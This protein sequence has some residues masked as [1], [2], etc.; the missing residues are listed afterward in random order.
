M[1]DTLGTGTTEDGTLENAVRG[2]F[3]FRPGAIIRDLDLLRPVYRQTA[4]YGHFG[5]EDDPFTWERTDRAEVL[6][7]QAS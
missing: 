3:N 7:K 5:R 1:V 2:V 4:C 6:Q